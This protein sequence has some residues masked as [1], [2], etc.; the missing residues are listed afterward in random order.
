MLYGAGRGQAGD[1]LCIVSLAYLSFQ[2][3]EPTK[4][5]CVVSVG[6]GVFQADELGDFSIQKY[7]R[8]GTHTLTFHRIFG[9][10]K[11]LLNLLGNAVSLGDW[12]LCFFCGGGGWLS[13]G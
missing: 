13:P 3:L 1:L 8:V 7:S 6:C 11:N 4:Y 9:E 12:G 2:L 5:A 10:L